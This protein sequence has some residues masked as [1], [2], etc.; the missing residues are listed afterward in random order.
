MK[1]PTAVAAAAVLALAVPVRAQGELKDVGVGVIVGDPIGGTVK[2]WLDERVAFDL[3]IGYSGD[4]VMWGDVL[5][6]A[7]N[8]LPKPQEGK[9]GLYLG[10]GPRLETRRDAEFAIRTIAG[11]AWRLDKQPVELFAEA[12]PLFRMTPRG[13]VGADAG[14]GLRMY[15]GR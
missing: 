12:G 15:L 2:V 6:H 7:W 9:L 10:A 5:V 14:I 11:V 13:G 8:I 4:T 3:G 1:I